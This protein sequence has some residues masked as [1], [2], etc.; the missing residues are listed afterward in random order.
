M[1]IKLL[2]LITICFQK[3]SSFITQFPFWIG[4]RETNQLS[5]PRINQKYIDIWFNKFPEFLLKGLPS[6][7]RKNRRL[8]IVR[9][10]VEVYFA[11]VR[12]NLPKV[13][14]KGKTLKGLCYSLNQ[15][16]CLNV[17]LDDGEVPIDNNATEQL[18]RGFCI[19]KKELD[20]S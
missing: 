18:I 7:E 3:F 4:K 17:F 20:D 1:M 9:S 15:E 12:E 14:Q 8:L 11:W 13:P 16:K 19:R 6:E 5:I 10:L 2:Y